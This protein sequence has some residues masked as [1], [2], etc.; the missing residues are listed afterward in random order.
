MSFEFPV[1]VKLQVGNICARASGFPFGF[2]VVL[3][4]Y[5]DYELVYL[6]LNLVVN[7]VWPYIT[8]LE[9]KWQV[10]VLQTQWFMLLLHTN[11]RSHTFLIVCAGLLGDTVVRFIECPSYSRSIREDSDYRHSNSKALS[12]G[13]KQHP[14]HVQCPLSLNDRSLFLTIDCFLVILI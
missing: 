3:S 10:N 4:S 14:S 5:A 2:S 7:P 6:L 13:Q 12:I 11:T 1:I 8:Q 9:C